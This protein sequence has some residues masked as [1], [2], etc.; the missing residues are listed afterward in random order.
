M[1]EWYFY[2]FTKLFL[3]DI[4]KNIFTATVTTESDELSVIFLS[5]EVSPTAC[6]Y[7]KL[8]DFNVNVCRRYWNG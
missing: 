2:H 6:S 7:F 3:K 4:N 5:F 1:V 8:L